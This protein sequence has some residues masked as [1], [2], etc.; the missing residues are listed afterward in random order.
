[1]YLEVVLCAEMDI[2]LVLEGSL[3]KI[4]SELILL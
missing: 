3:E 2:G 1:M 4:H